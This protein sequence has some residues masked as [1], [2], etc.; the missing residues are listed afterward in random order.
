MTKKYLVLRCSLG[1]PRLLFVFSAVFLRD[2]LLCY[3]YDQDQDI[4]RY[5]PLKVARGQSTRGLPPTFSGTYTSST[6]I[7]GSNGICTSFT[8]PFDSG[9]RFLRALTFQ[10]KL[11]TGLFERR[12][13]I[14]RLCSSVQPGHAVHDGCL[15]PRVNKLPPCISPQTPKHTRAITAGSTRFREF[16]YWRW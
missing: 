7:A 16:E 6:H 9:W 1:K 12:M 8:N 13:K 3:E 15:R 11:H 5:Q 10:I 14:P 2:K 4:L